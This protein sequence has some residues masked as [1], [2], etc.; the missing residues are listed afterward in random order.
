MRGGHP[1]GPAQHPRRGRT[2]PPCPGGSRLVRPVWRGVRSLARGG[3]GPG[4]RRQR[5]GP[6]PGGQRNL[7]PIDRP[8][9]REPTRRLPASRRSGAS[10]PGRVN[11]GEV[12]IKAV[13]RGEPKMLSG[14]DQK[15]R[16]QVR[17][18]QCP[19]PRMTRHRPKGT[20]LPRSDRR[21]ERSNPVVSPRGKADC[22]GG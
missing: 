9:T 21:D 12:L 4:R 7:D 3:T 5:R 10:S 2:P 15:V 6:K 14:S 19:P 16:G 18:L 11:P 13:N 1:D 8:W 22:E 20:T 17:G